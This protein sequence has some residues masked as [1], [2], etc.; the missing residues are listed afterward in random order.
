MGKLQGN[1]PPR[2]VFDGF[3]FL[4]DNE[5]YPG[6]KPPWGL[7]NC[8]DLS[9]GKVLWRVPLGELEKLTRQ[10]VPV[11]GSRGLGGGDGHRGRARFLR[12]DRG[13]EASRFRRRHR[14][15]ALVGEAAICRNCR[16]GRLRDRRPRICR[17]YGVRRWTSGGTLG[18]GRC[19]RGVCPG[20][21]GRPVTRF[22]CRNASF[23][24]ITTMKSSSFRRLRVPAGLLGV[25][26]LGAT[27]KAVSYASDALL[28][29]G[30]PPDAHVLKIGDRAPDFSLLGVDGK[31]YTLADFKDAPLLMVIFMSNHCAVSHASETRVFPYYAKIKGQ[32]VAVVAINPNDPAGIHEDEL[33]YTQYNDGYADM[34][35]YAKDRNFP[36][37]YLYDGETQTTAKAYGC[38]CTPHVFLFDRDRRLRYAGRFD[39]SRLPDPQ[40]VTVSD[41]PNAIEALLAGRPVPVAETRAV[42]CSTK[43]ALKT[44]ADVGSN[45][46]KAWAGRSPGH[47]G[48]PSTP[49]GRCGG[50]GP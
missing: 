39:N 21:A 33:G 38:L 12:R 22:F 37:P 2:Y 49:P 35:R 3:R 23:N 4:E 26:F 20:P 18:G 43:W 7:L 50:A 8:Y 1:V 41:A 6:I 17:H 27:A 34:K 44:V 31:K 25:L 5:G 24:G 32:G 10:G 30:L 36:F 15:G 19:L 9:T 13:R 40:S 45:S 42:G 14:G 46:S 28:K 29:D 47:G 11:T 16:A 48:A